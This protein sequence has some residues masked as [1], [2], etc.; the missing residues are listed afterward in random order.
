MRCLMFQFSKVS[1]GKSIHIWTEN[2]N[3]KIKFLYKTLNG[4]TIENQKSFKIVF[5]KIKVAVI[6]IQIFIKVF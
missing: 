6:K 5:L 3:Y 4:I 1:P 2:I